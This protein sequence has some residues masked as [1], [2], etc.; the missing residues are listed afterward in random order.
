MMK[1]KPPVEISKA[2]MEYLTTLKERDKRHFIACKAGVPT[3]ADTV[4]SSKTL[5]ILP[6]ALA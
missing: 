5:W 6:T 2:E 3:P 1:K 4:S